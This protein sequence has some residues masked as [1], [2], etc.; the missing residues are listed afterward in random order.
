[1]ISEYSDEH[2]I[3]LL[4]ENS[5]EAKDILYERYKGKIDYLL[6][7]HSVLAKSLGIDLLDLEQEALVGF[8]D[9]I[10][11][12]NSNKDASLV[13]FICLCVER[14]IKKACIKAGTQKNKAMKETLSL[15]YDY[16]SEEG[17]SSLKD[18]IEDKDSDPLKQITQKEEYNELLKEIKEEF[19]PQENEVFELMLIGLNYKDIALIL[20]KMP[21]QVDNAIQRI[22]IKVRKVLEK[23]Q[24][25]I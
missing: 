9:A 1:M 17:E 25:L 7:K 16:D 13:T 19:S 18:I 23:R 10:L 22:K 5:D 21:K 24:I 2:L 11:N 12:Y 14:K 20:D 3:E 6:K 8:T 15:D 4:H